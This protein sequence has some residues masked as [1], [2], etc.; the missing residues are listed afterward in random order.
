MPPHLLMSSAYSNTSNTTNNNSDEDRPCPSCR[1]PNSMRTDWAQ[2]DRVCTSCGVVD[3]ERLLDDRPDWK[4]FGEAED[5]IKGLPSGARCG[6][7]PVDES[8]YMGGLQPTGL[9]K[10]PFGAASFD[11]ASEH[12]RTSLATTNRKM[13]SLV[14]KQH[15]R[16]L[17]RAKLSRLI[18]RKQQHV[19]V[20]E[21]QTADDDYTIA[22][23]HD[24]LVLHEEQEAE[25]LY[26]AL[27]GEK[28]S[29]DRALLLHSNSNTSNSN[30][31]TERDDLLAR[32]DAPLKRAASDLYMAY[33]ILTRAAQRLELP[34]A[35][36]TRDATRAMCRYAT[37]KDGLTVQGVSSRLSSSTS[38][39][40]TTKEAAAALTNYNKQKQ[41]AA[42]AAA[43][44]FL[45]ARKHGH[46]R[47]MKEVCASFSTT[48]NGDNDDKIL[49]LELKTKH[50]G[51][52][53]N[54]LR[55]LFPEYMRASSV[56]SSSSSSTAA[57]A[58]NPQHFVEHATRKLK[59][60]PVATACIQALVV[61]ECT[62]KP[63]GGSNNNKLLSTTCAS[64]TLFIT[65]V[66]TV[67]Q[68]LAQQAAPYQ[69]S[70]SSPPPPAKRLKTDH[71][72][73]TTTSSRSATASFDLF[74]HP[75]LDIKTYEMRQ[76]W[77]A[78]S[79]QVSWNRSVADISQS[80]Q[81]AQVAL[82]EHF[83]TILYPKRA[84][85]LSNLSTTTEQLLKNTPRAVV[86]LSQIPCASPLLNPQG[87]V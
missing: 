73:T 47:L 33:S 19:V 69:S 44:L 72:T 68:R 53:M 26:A 63:E 52:A 79:E 49:Q 60:P 28:W 71:A 24:Q 43:L 50:C 25:R 34:L 22:P 37:H 84:Q 3:D 40:T 30:S 17:K 80:C 5:I 66:G 51:K 38:T 2:G 21:E 45:E 6:L 65:M 15:K 87:T 54:E 31:T 75:A 59:L 39:T 8:K 77:D 14:A 1:A 85:L 41:M 46:A 55:A 11:A 9:S 56:M 61:Q 4:E 27:Q 10:R 16:A 32:L 13:D 18:Q 82:L 35:T 76:V 42:L 64:V 7:V 58:A 29:L 48:N 78:W 36:V 81:V 74:A 23:E 70:S 62:T 20:V 83:T 12:I 86:L 67:M 57:A